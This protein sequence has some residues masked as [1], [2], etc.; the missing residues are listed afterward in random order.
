MPHAPLHHEALKTCCNILRGLMALLHP[1]DLSA[2]SI[3]LSYRLFILYFSL[4]PM[5]S[6]YIFI[7]VR[8]RTLLGGLYLFTAYALR[9][10][11]ALRNLCCYL[12]IPIAY[13]EF[14]I[15]RFRVYRFCPVI[16]H[17]ITHMD[18]RTLPIA[19]RILSALLPERPQIFCKNAIVCS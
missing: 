17:T 10:N 8:C 16:I 5:S 12:G 6:A 2:F 9:C 7:A 4:F 11:I 1:D 15:I 14:T 19:R 13:Y 18:G 3:M